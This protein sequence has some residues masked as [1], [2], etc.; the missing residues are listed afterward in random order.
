MVPDGEVPNEP[1][2]VGPN[3]IVFGISVEHSGKEGRF[4][5]R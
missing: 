1:L 3:V 5:G 4:C 2:A